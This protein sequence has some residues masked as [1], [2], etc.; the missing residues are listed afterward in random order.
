MGPGLLQCCYQLPQG[1]EHCPSCWGGERRLQ[2]REVVSSVCWVSLCQASPV[3]TR[4]PSAD[5]PGT[6]VSGRTLGEG[7]GP[8]PPDPPNHTK[9]KSSG[10][11]QDQAAVSL[12]GWAVGPWAPRSSSCCLTQRAA[13]GLNVTSRRGG[14]GRAGAGHRPRFGWAGQLAQAPSLSPHPWQRQQR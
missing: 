12:N 3:S 9:S 6:S 14:R 10:A 2:Q 4:R 11:G 7:A 13:S 8:E 1:A 5:L